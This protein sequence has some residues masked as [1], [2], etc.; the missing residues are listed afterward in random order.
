MKYN[1]IN[2]NPTTNEITF[3]VTD[4]G[5]FFDWPVLEIEGAEEEVA[6]AAADSNP[7]PGS[8]KVAAA[9]KPKVA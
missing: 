6:E 9:A 1:W 7:K 5:Y 2:V 4:T 8:G 3:P